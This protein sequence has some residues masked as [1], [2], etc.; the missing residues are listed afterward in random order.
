MISNSYPF[1]THFNIHI[2]A[3]FSPLIPTESNRFCARKMQLYLDTAPKVRQ[4]S[5][6][7]SNLGPVGPG[8]P[9]LWDR[10]PARPKAPETGL[11]QSEV[12]AGSG[13]MVQ[14]QTDLPE[15]T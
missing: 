9:L 11:W 14:S 4:K 8:L 13:A 6:K 5:L 7:W 15:P 2:E 3:H 12:F 10:P 1:N